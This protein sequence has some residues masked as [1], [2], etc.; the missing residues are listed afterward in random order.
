MQSFD[1][2][3]DLMLL[4]LL[5]ETNLSNKEIA[6]ELALT[7]EE[8]SLKIKSLGLGWI[9]KGRGFASRGQASLAAVI[10]KLLPREEIIC[11]Y[12]IGDRLR[13]DIFCPKYQL[14]VEYHGR[15]HF[16]YIEFFH[17]D[18]HGFDEHYKRDMRKVEICKERGIAL[19]V[20]R[21]NDLLTEEVVLERLM[22]AIASTK[23]VTNTKPTLKGNPA[24]EAFKQRQREYRRQTYQR[25]KRGRK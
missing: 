14:A 3:D 22:E 4:D 6:K 16:E 24:Y 9:R 23:T 20:F 10:K 13:L 15:Q 25:M 18:A 19:V 2:L 17:K 7:S 11:E 8:V 21:Y 5:L 1:D 12:P